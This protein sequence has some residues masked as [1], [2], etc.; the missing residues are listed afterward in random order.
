MSAES[1]RSW[2]ALPACGLPLSS[3]SPC[4]PQSYQSRQAS[5]AGAAGSQQED[6]DSSDSEAA[7]SPSSDERRIIET[8]THRY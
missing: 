7:D 4:L 1:G 2:G 8:P 3:A 5:M 6:E